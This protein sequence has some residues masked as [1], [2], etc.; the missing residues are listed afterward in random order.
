LVSEKA[1][2]FSRRG[3]TGFCARQVICPTG[4]SLAFSASTFAA[5]DQLR[6]APKITE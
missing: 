3:W 2:Y 5:R 1:K 4:K 6:R